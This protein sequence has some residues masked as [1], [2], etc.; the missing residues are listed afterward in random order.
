M[1]WGGTR[2]DLVNLADKKDERGR[3]RALDGLATVVAWGS[4]P[5]LLLSGSMTFLK[6]LEPF[7]PQFLH[8]KR[9]RSKN[10]HGGAGR[11]GC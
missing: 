7:V 6:T 2:K 9:S 1:K 5:P 10:S 8:L 4:M 11:L 3:W